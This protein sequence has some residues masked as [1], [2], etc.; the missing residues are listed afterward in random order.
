[1]T[2]DCSRRKKYIVQKKTQLDEFEIQL[3]DK[4]AELKKNQ[5]TSDCG[6]A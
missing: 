5:G 6:D 2:K 1:M 4:R 3:N